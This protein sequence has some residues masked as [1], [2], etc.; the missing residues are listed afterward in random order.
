MNYDKRETN[1]E[2]TITYNGRQSKLK[3]FTCT[4]LYL[5]WMMEQFNSG[6]LKASESD[7]SILVIY[8][9]FL[10]ITKQIYERTVKRH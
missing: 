4:L 7:K 9:A 1:I 10:I 8:L 3:W 6:E 2:K 5:I